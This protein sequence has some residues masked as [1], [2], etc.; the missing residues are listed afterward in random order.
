MVC[1]VALNNECKNI[2]HLAGKLRFI[3]AAGCCAAFFMQEA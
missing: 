1:E 3:A 2:R